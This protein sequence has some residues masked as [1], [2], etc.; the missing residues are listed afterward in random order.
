LFFELRGLRLVVQMVIHGQDVEWAGAATRVAKNLGVSKP[1]DVQA[2]VD[3]ANA[4]TAGLRNQVVG[5]QQF[6]IKRDP[7]RLHESAM[8]N[9]IADAMRLKY[10]GVDAAYTNSSGLCQEQEIICY[11][12]YTSPC[13]PPIFAHGGRN[14]NTASSR[15]ATA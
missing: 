10:P 5:T 6:D 12:S 13:N 4:Q 3:D 14:T 11:L 8:G 1:P 2:I 9:M 7:T 15:H